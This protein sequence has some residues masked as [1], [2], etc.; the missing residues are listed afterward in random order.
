[1][2]FVIELGLAA[3]PAGAAVSTRKAVRAVCFHG[4]ALLLIR[5]NRGDLKFPGGGLEPG[6]SPEAAL[7]REVL[8]ETGYRVTGV[9]EVMGRTVERNPDA[10]QAGA[11]FEMES[12]YYA[13][14]VDLTER[15]RQALEDYEREQGFT[16]GFLPPSEA[17]ERN[18]KLLAEQPLELNR[19]VRRDT[20]V[21]AELMGRD[22]WR[23][24]SF[25]CR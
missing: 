5:T 8:E 3:L 25:I 14:T 21:L 13:C 23:G 9:G 15:G 22:M 1:M 24:D 16:P 6:E 4:G 7:R 18:R 2:A 12:V 19:W 17:L 20:A 11:Y 10:F